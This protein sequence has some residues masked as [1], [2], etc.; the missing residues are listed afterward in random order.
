MHQIRA[1]QQ[2]CSLG[3]NTTSATAPSSGPHPV[4]VGGAH[5]LDARDAHVVLAWLQ[6]HRRRRFLA[7][8]GAL[9]LPLAQLS[10]RHKRRPAIPPHAGR[11][12]RATRLRHAAAA[13]LRA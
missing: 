11:E 6:R 5:G 12:G 2:N 7:A 13:A 8:D 1:A 3:G 10:R 9:F 4:D